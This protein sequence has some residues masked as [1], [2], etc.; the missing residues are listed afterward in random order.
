MLVSVHPPAALSALVFSDRPRFI[1]ILYD[2]VDTLCSV[3]QE[4]ANA[5][6]LF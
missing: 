2:G 5:A 6:G 3:E 1:G 4:T